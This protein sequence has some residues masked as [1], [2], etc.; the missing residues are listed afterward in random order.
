M[1]AVR[2]APEAAAS[3]LVVCLDA[4]EYALPIECVAEVLPM[5]ALPP[6]PEAPS[7]FAGMLNL[8]GQAI[9]VID[10]RSRLSLPCPEP[11]LDTPLIVT[12]AANR[13]CAFIA[14][15]IVEVL[16]LPADAVRP[17][18]EAAGSA[19]AVSGL[20]KAGDRLIVILDVERLYSAS[21]TL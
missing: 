21:A 19:H 1:L 9:P 8:R 13:T 3:Y 2:V 10:L 4:H 6:I 5:V 17:P 20:A 11:G 15:S 18:D 14:D 16:A 7:W 12:R